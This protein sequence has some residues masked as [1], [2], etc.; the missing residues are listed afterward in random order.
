MTVAKLSVLEA[1]GSVTLEVT[2]K[3]AVRTA[4]RIRLGALLIRMAAAVMGCNVA[5]S[6]EGPARSRAR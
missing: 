4:L 5:L 3:S 2:V 1:M 6:I